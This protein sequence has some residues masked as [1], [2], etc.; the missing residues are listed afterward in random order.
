QSVTNMSR[1]TIF[2]CHLQ[3]TG[4]A[5]NVPII[6][7]SNARWFVD[8]DVI[9][10]LKQDQVFKLIFFHCCKSTKVYGTKRYTAS[11]SSY[12]SCSF[13]FL[14]PLVTNTT[15]TIPAM[16]SGILNHCPIFNARPSSKSTWFSFKNSYR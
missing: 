8:H 14:L 13:C 6:Q 3:D 11:L 7:R 4:N 1:C 2:P 15:M 5:R 12:A 16:N 9:L 10:V